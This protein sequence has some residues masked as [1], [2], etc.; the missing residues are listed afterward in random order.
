M[1]DV[2][3]FPMSNHLNKET[4]GRKRKTVEKGSDREVPTEGVLVSNDKGK[5]SPLA[6]KVRAV[7]TETLLLLPVLLAS[8]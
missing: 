8:W 7:R 6:R 5:S 1:V 2:G 4:K 3:R